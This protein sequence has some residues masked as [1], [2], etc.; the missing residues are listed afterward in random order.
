MRVVILQIIVA[1]R[2]VMEQ[3][4]HLEETHVLSTSDVIRI[5]YFRPVSCAIY[6]E[7]RCGT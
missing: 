7:S 6:S 5:S 4:C 3:L 2:R 1:V